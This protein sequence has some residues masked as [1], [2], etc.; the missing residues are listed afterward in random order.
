[1]IIGTIYRPPGANIETFLEVINDIL[2]KVTPEQKLCYL[3][4]DYR[5]SIF[6][7]QIHTS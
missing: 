7:M 2:E 3:L 1:M 6:L 4:G 5:S